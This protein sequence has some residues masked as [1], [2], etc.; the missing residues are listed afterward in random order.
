[1]S[2]KVRFLSFFYRLS[3]IFIVSCILERVCD[4]I[5]SSYLNRENALQQDLFEEAAYMRKN[6][7]T[8]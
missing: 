8:N 3:N 4:D 7:K 1:M 2:V 6:L 5:S